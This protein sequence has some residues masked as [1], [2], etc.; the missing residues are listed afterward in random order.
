MQEILG[1]LN[2]TEQR[3][4][5]QTRAR[6][7]IA[8]HQLEVVLANAVFRNPLVLVQNS[9]QQLD[10]LSADLEEFIKLLLTKAHRE[11]SA[12][13]EQIIRI[14]PHRLI[15]YKTIELN[16]WENRANVGI[17]AAVNNCRMQ[18]TAKE[19]RLSALNPR[20]VLQRGYSITTNK[21]TGLLVKTSGDVSIGDF[22]ITELANENLIE[23]EVKKK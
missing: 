7:K 17:R 11:L 12:A 20:S 15:G 3:L 19:N 1:Q 9:R 6:L 22:L 8:E 16:N 13:Y 2:S 23:S 10:D 21:Q 5:S 4:A 14:E 18:L